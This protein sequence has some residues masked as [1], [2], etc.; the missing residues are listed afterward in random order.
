MRSFSDWDKEIISHLVRE[1]KGI[2]Y[3]MD[4]FLTSFYLKAELGKALIIQAQ[5]KYAVF[6]LKTEFYDQEETKNKELTQFLDLLSLLKLLIADGYLAIHK[7]DQEKDKSMFFLQDSFTNPQPTSGTIY[8]NA[9]GDYTSNPETIHDRNKQVIYK[10]IVFEREMYDLILGLTTGSYI[11]SQNID[12]LLK[13]NKSGSLSG[14]RGIFITILLLVTLVGMS[15]FFFVTGRHQQEEQ[16]NQYQRVIENHQA[17]QYQLDD[18]NTKIQSIN[19]HI[20]SASLVQ[21]SSENTNPKHY[22]IDVSKW[23]GNI[24]S[25]LDEIDSIAFVICKATEGRHSVDPTFKTNWAL[26]RKKGLIRGAYHFYLTDDDPIQQAEHFWSVIQQLDST[27]MTPIVDIEQGSISSDT[28]NDPV[29]IQVALLL[30]LRH[31]EVKSKR[32]PMIYTG[33]DFANQYLTHNSF[34]A[35]PLWLADYTKKEKPSIPNTWKDKGFMIWQRSDSYTINS[36]NIDLDVFYG[37][38]EQF[39]K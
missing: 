12:Q 38:K 20:S 7:A 35:Y 11:V 27:D 6:F 34:A 14:Q 25:E 36:N 10:G 16:G 30:F 24:Q 39:Y 32:L 9:A 37:E 5:R 8:L 26:L 23:N 21:Q 15:T 22:G 2:S 13:V 17:I 28:E 3:P 33:L 31:L 29:K 4:T 19:T 1:K 18:L